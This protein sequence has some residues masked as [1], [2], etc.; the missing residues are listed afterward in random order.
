L[1]HFFELYQGVFGD[2]ETTFC[3][4]ESSLLEWRIMGKRRTST[5]SLAL[6]TWGHEMGKDKGME[7]LVVATASMDG[8]VEGKGQKK[9]SKAIERLRWACV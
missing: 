4:S 6:Y 1:F 8:E 3:F 2:V 7:G 5:M 9:I